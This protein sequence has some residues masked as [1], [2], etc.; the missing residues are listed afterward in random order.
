[1][2]LSDWQDDF[3][4][5]LRGAASSPAAHP[6]FAVY[7]NTVWKGWIDALVANFPA[8]ARLAGQD[9]MRG[10]CAAYAETAP[11]SHPALVRYGDGFP[12][13]LAAFPQARDWP[14]LADVASI[15]RAWTLAHVAADDVAL[16]PGAL[17]GLPPS[18][19]TALGLRLRASVQPLWFGW[20]IPD[21]W[22]A[23]RGDFSGGVHALEP[24]PQGVLVWRPAETVEARLIDPADFAFLDACRLGASLSDAADAALAADPD[25]DLSALVSTLLAAEVFA[26]PSSEPRP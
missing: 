16:A 22:L 18:A 1:M 15:D 4:S 8:V 6:A 3:A 14:F 13:F 25:A 12:A 20:T 5:G 24:K 17:V 9:W 2:T 10:V 7:R 23:N 11:P 21:L 26:A 19:M